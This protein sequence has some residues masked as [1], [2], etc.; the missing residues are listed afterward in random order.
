M[1]KYQDTMGVKLKRFI[2]AF[3][4][5]MIWFIPLV[6][7]GY[8]AHMKLPLWCDQYFGVLEAQQTVERLSQSVDALSEPVFMT[9]MSIAGYLKA[10][11]LNMTASAKVYTLMSLSG[12]IAGLGRLIL[13][14]IFIIG[15]ICVIRRIRRG[16]RAAYQESAV[17]NHICLELMPEIESLKREIAELRAELQIKS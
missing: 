10:F 3:L 5:Q 7:I 9:P 15:L 14:V 11:I 1:K 13:D 2:L 4:L 17:V 16:Y 8:Y 6:I 12:I